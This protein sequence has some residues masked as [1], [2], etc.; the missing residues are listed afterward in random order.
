[1]FL[2]RKT[3]DRPLPRGCTYPS[4]EAHGRTTNSSSYGAGALTPPK[5]TP[6]PCRR[7]DQKRHPTPRKR[8]HKIRKSQGEASIDRIRNMIPKP[9]IHWQGL[10]QTISRYRFKKQIPRGLSR[11]H[12]GSSCP[13]PCILQ[14]A[15]AVPA[16]KRYYQRTKLQPAAGDGPSSTKVVLPENE[17]PAGRRRLPRIP[18][19]MLRK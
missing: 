16:L 4:T 7:P 9:A 15:T 17:N 10:V 2:H 19:F 1:M 12:V 8:H 3:L 6:S 11:E 14:P 13:E 18:Q 5:S